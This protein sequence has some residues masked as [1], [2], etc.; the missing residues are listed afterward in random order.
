MTD[1]PRGIRNNNP[2][3]IRK[4]S[5]SWIGLAPQQSD[6]DFCQFTMPVWGIRAGMKCIQHI[7]VDVP[8]ATVSE[9]IGKWAPPCENDTKAYVQDVCARAHC[10][11]DFVFPADNVIWLASLASAIVEHENGQQP[12]SWSLYTAAAKLACRA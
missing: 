9:I 7:C 3:N 2:M 5:G 12:Y 6:A 10:D 4:N 11:P 1:I 8:D